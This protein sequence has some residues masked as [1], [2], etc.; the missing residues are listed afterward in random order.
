MRFRPATVAI[1]AA[2]AALVVARTAGASDDPYFDRQ[3]NL[4]QVGAPEAWTHATGKGITIGI[5]D[6]GV[7]SANP[8]LAGKIDAQA[9]CIGGPCRESPAR[10]GQ[11][12]GT[13]VAGIAAANTGNGV[14]IAGVAPDAHLIVAK[15][16]SDDGAGDT[17]D[18]NNGI[19][20]VVD[21]GARIVNL[22]L[23][24]AS[25]TLTARLGSPLAAGIEYAWTKGAI[26]VLAAGNYVVGLSDGSSANYGNLDAVVVGATDK[27]G[28]VAWYSTPLGN[29][30]WGVVAPGGGDEKPDTGIASPELKNAFG[31]LAGTSMAAPHVS[32][33]LALLLQQGL[34]ATGA[35]ERL[36]ATLDHTA[37]CGD[38]CRGRLKIDAA[39]TPPAPA[40]TTTSTVPPTGSSRPMSPLLILGGAI[41]LIAG[42]AGLIRRGQRHK[43]TG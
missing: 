13:A 4:T 3:W 5:V 32:G 15:A 19:Q 36:L 9:N 1:A 23:G 31:W 26:P 22:S 11:G 37:P 30:K 25:A 38:G 41:A 28:D 17:E 12:H 40:A 39:V 34:T 42:T 6:T 35:V 16:L 33:A 29:A 43:H 8:E 20:W 7:D 27:K 10:D 24:D 14:G 18:I 2:V 21:H